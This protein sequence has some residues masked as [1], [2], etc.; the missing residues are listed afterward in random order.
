M[1][2]DC[3][4]DLSRVLLSLPKDVPLYVVLDAY[5]F[6]CTQ[7]SL[8]EAFDLAQGVGATAVFVETRGASEERLCLKLKMAN[9][10]ILHQFNLDEHEDEDGTLDMDDL[11]AALVSWEDSVSN[12]DLEGGVGVLDA[13]LPLVNRQ[14]WEQTCGRDDLV[15]VMTAQQRVSKLEGSNVRTAKKS[16]PRA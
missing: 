5:R 13:W 10:D 12:S 7:E 1:S 4:S 6:R 15:A 8:T 16:R 9:G 11:E 3:V 2:E 14:Y